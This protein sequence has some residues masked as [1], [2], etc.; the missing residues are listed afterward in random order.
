MDYL[1]DETLKSKLMT[2]HTPEHKKSILKRE[3]SSSQNR[4][5]NSSSLKQVVL[6]SN[7]RL[8]SKRILIKVKKNLSIES[9]PGSALKTPVNRE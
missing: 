5:L 3:H 8:S 6:K 2:D 4:Y 1:R 9:T 7:Q